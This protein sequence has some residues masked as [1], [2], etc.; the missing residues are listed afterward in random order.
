MA[1]LSAEVGDIP[2][3]AGGYRA[4]GEGDG[5]CVEAVLGDFVADLISRQA[6]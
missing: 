4:F 5:L 6:Q 2:R 3:R 1:R